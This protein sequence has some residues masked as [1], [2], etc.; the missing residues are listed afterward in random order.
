VVANPPAWLRLGLGVLPVGGG[1]EGIEKRRSV[2]ERKITTLVE[3]TTS[4]DA[5]KLAR[6]SLSVMAATFLG[7]GLMSLIAPK[8]LK[9]LVIHC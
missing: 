5:M 8:N 2:T 1:V 7:L 6:L 3:A 9:Q 4:G